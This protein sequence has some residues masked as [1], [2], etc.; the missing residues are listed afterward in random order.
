MQHALDLIYQQH[1]Q[2]YQH[3]P[4]YQ[5]KKRTRSADGLGKHPAWLGHRI[6]G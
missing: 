2:G 4:Q 1:S 6:S 5:Q 3:D